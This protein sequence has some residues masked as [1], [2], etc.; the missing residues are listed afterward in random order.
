MPYSFSPVLARL[1]VLV[2]LD[3][4]HAR[5]VADPTSLRRTG[6]GGGLIARG[7]IDRPHFHCVLLGEAQTVVCGALPN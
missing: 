7:G 1:S 5:I 4:L 3:I 6:N 2:R